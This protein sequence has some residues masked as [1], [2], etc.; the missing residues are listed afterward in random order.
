MS[1]VCRSSHVKS[2]TANACKWIIVVFPLRLAIKM[3]STLEQ[4]PCTVA[5]PFFRIAYT[6]LPF[7]EA[8]KWDDSLLKCLSIPL[9]IVISC[10]GCRCFSIGTDTRF[11]QFCF[12][13]R[14]AKWIFMA[15]IE[16]DLPYRRKRC[17]GR[18]PFCETTIFYSHYQ[19]LV[20]YS[21]HRFSLHFI[22]FHWRPFNRLEYLL[23]KCYTSCG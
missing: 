22:N 4:K 9:Y 17:V 1:G 8:K 12:T 2:A 3:S 5:S 15:G 19:W 7:D 16:F 20:Q 14:N 23:N 13:A 10:N 11:A 6:R 21:P 18:W